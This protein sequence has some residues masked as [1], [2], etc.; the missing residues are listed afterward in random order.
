MYL[1]TLQSLSKWDATK[2][3]SLL[4]MLKELLRYY[5]Q[6]NN[7][8]AANHLRL[9]QDVSSLLSAIDLDSSDLELYI[10]GTEVGH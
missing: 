6:H 1:C 8:R 4:L 2:Q 7:I 3:D 9:Q 5:R 10:T